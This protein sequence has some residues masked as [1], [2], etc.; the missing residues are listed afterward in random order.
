MIGVILLVWAILGL[1]Y[2]VMFVTEYHALL[3]KYGDVKLS[4]EVALWMP[5]SVLG[6]VLF[7]WHS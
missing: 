1:I 3:S 5:L 7:I 2:Q 6:Q 4:R